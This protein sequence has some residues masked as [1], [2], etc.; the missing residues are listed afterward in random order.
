M[1]QETFVGLLGPNLKG[2]RN[3]VQRHLWGSGHEDDILQQTLLHAFVHR[4]QLRAHSKFKS[5]L[6]SIAINEIRGFLRGSRSTVSLSEYT[7]FELTDRAPSP[8]ANYEQIE[9]R[10][11]LQAGLGR[12]SERDR[13][14]IRLL[15]FNGWSIAE[16]AAALSVSSAAVKSIHFRALRR[17]GRAL[18]EALLNP[19]SLKGGAKACRR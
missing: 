6:W 5:W 17:L 3:F 15:N 11:W 7:D 2:L 8:L 19:Q 4:D 14:A 9:R 10:E 13:T 12:L 16:T 18:H 1:S